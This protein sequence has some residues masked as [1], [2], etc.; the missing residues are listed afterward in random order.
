[1]R[2]TVPGLRCWFYS[3]GAAFWTVGAHKLPITSSHTMMTPVAEKWLH[4]S[5]MWLPKSS[6]AS[7]EYEDAFAVSGKDTV[8][9][10]SESRTFRAAVADGA[11]EPVFSGPWANRLAAS[12]V[13][14]GSLEPAVATVRENFRSR[15]KR[16]LPWYLE[17][18]AEEGAHAAVLGLELHGDEIGR[19]WRATAV[20]DCCLFQISNGGTV[21]SWPPDSPAAFNNT[22]A[23]ISSSADDPLPEF[24]ATSGTWRAGD[25]FILATDALAAFLKSCGA[26]TFLT[27]AGQFDEFVRDAR[28]DG[29]MFDDDVTAIVVELR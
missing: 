29:R 22:P 10:R 6:H 13:Q 19:E 20:G 25:A 24:M 15:A 2:A 21:V 18:K 7:H 5:T 23:L 27:N 12:F 26:R 16:R 4:V 11:T 17:E 1:M 8:L 3:A 28:A 9:V 14:H